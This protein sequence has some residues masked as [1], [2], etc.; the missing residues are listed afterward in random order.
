MQGRQWSWVHMETACLGKCTPI[1][2]D[3][4]LFFSICVLVWHCLSTFVFCR[5]ILCLS[6]QHQPIM[7]FS[8][9]TLCTHPLMLW[10]RRSALSAKMSMICGNS[11][12]VFSIPQK[13]T[14]CILMS[15]LNVFISFVVNTLHYYID[16]FWI[17]P[18][19]LHP[20]HYS[21]LGKPS[22]SNRKSILIF[23][24]YN[25]IILILTVLNVFEYMWKNICSKNFW[26]DSNLQFSALF[27]A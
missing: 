1:Y 3:I 15:D 7:N 21:L 18:I 19:A 24:I 23:V 4:C 27:N 25:I 2:V 8:F 10:R 26:T 17:W 20:L 9:T 5:T 12:L 11:I 14:K 16:S 13:T 22:G 6:R